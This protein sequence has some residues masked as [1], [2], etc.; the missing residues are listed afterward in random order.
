MLAGTKEYFPSV[1]SL[2][3]IL[4]ACIQLKQMAEILHFFIPKCH[5][6][7]IIFMT[8]ISNLWQ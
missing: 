5:S 1:H 3:S 2:E 7:F 4:V 8:I 6:L